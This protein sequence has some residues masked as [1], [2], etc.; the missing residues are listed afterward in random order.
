MIVSNDKIKTYKQVLRPL[1]FLD[2]FSF[3]PTAWELWHYLDKEVSLSE[4]ENTLHKL[5]DRKVIKKIQVFY[6]LSGRDNI[7]KVR[8]QRYNYFVSKLKKARVFS[9]LFSL[10]PGV[11]MVAAANFIGSHNWRQESDIAVSYTH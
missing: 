11:I 10:F 9:C 1:I 8:R 7:V 3:P 2:L 4:I 6:F 5:E